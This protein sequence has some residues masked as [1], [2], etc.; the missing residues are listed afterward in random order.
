MQGNPDVLPEQVRAMEISYDHPHSE[1][2]QWRIA[3]FY[4]QY[5]NMIDFVYSLPIIAVNR[6]G[7]TGKGIEY[8]CN[9]QPINYFS[10]SGQY[11]YLDMEDR[12]GDPILYR[13]NHRS[14]LSA[15]LHTNFANIRFSVRY[16]SE[17][18]YDDF[19]SHDYEVIGTKIIF[20]LKTLPAQT[21]PEIIL[22]KK[23][24]SYKAT[25]K[26]SNLLD[27]TYELIQDYPMPGRTWHITLTKTL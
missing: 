17:Q 10:F 19:L 16:W 12:G 13:S 6:E 26:I 2:W 25:L 27:T 7:V 14:N 1:S 3:T 18:Q 23:L 20:P 8:Q 5:E 21:I 24:N 9:W 11:E 4:N 22:S 15:Q